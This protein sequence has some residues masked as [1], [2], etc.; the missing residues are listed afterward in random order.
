MPEPPPFGIPEISSDCEEN[1]DAYGLSTVVEPFCDAGSFQ[2]LSSRNGRQIRPLSGARHGLPGFNEKF[3]PSRS[4]KSGSA[5]TLL[6]TTTPVILGW[7]PPSP[8]SRGPPNTQLL[9][10]TL[11]VPTGPPSGQKVSRLSRLLEFVITLRSTTLSF[12]A[13]VSVPDRSTPSPLPSI[14]L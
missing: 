1:S 13:T 9:R 2:M 8:L 7:T 4:T 6:L 11:P 10:N 12:E 14:V 3:L 5:T